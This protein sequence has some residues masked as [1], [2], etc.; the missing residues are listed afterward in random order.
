MENNKKIPSV[1]RWG[2][3]W[4][5][6]ARIFGLPLVHIALGINRETGKLYVA[7]GVV[8]IGFFG[9]GLISIAWFGIGLVLAIGQFAAGTIAIAQFAFGIYFGLGQFGT[10]AIA[11]GQFALGDH[12]LA[13]IGYGTHV[14][15]SIT[16]DLQAL[17]FFQNTFLKGH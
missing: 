7:K 4:K 12:V 9:F 3:E 15:S 11:I 6:R 1:L 10:G 14:W 13:Q 16:K 5:T 8:A 2:F 17:E